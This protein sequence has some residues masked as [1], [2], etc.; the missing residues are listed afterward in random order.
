MSAD[1]AAAFAPALL[2]VDLS[3]RPR[4]AGNRILAVAIG[5]SVLFHAVVL[6]IRFVPPVN[7]FLENLAPPLEVVLVNSKS[8]HKPPKADALAQATLDGGGN[9]EQ[10]RRAK[11]N[12]P[13]LTD[14]TETDAVSVASQRVQQLEQQVQAMMTRFESDH[15]VD[16]STQPSKQPQEKADGRHPSEVDQQKLAIERLQAQIARQVDRYQ[17]LPKRKFIGARTDSVIYAQYVD[18]WRRRIERV[19]T[20]NFPQEAKRAGIFGTLLLTV[21]I[22][23]D[24]SVEKVEVE[25]SSGFPILDKAALRI[26]ELAGPFAPFPPAIKKEFDILSITRSWQFTREEEL[27]G[28]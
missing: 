14:S 26:V 20:R 15:L 4:S 17:K 21:S 24:G 5:L 9:T 27:V 22:R 8:A 28:E 10:E 25:R 3:A 13:V 19:G 12:L 2:S 1:S 6:T 18:D 7:R 23:A 11:T 16:A